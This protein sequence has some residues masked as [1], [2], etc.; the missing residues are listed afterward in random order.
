[1]LVP[2]IKVNLDFLADIFEMSE[3]NYFDLRD[4]N[5]DL[6][7][8]MFENILLKGLQIDLV[9]TLPIFKFVKLIGGFYKTGEVDD[10]GREILITNPQTIQIYKYF[11]RHINEKHPIYIE[12][13]VEYLKKFFSG[14]IYTFISEKITIDKIGIFAQIF[15]KKWNKLVQNNELSSIDL[16]EISPRSMVENKQITRAKT[17]FSDQFKEEGKLPRYVLGNFKEY[18]TESYSTTAFS[19]YNFFSFFN[20]I[21]IQMDQMIQQI[22]ELAYPKE[23]RKKQLSSILELDKKYTEYFLEPN[24]VK[25]TSDFFEVVNNNVLLKHLPGKS[26]ILGDQFSSWVTLLS[27]TNSKIF[28]YSD[29]N[30]KFKNQFSAFFEKILKTYVLYNNF[31]STKKYQLEKEGTQ[32]LKELIMKI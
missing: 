18:P 19:F 3:S 13:M 24:S 30:F 6:F 15:I 7:Q 12:I 27:F 22:L 8:S 20:V 9:N 16:S 25:M 32:D 5:Q 4:S 29:D 17:R 2:Q 21:D 28:Q 1:M 10:K 26:V 23:I 14:T 11:A 31:F